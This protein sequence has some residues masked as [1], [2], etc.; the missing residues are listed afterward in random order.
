MSRSLYLVLPDWEGEIDNV[1][2]SVVEDLLHGPRYMQVG[3]ELWTL[4]GREER[5][6][7]IEDLLETAHNR[8]S[9]SLDTREVQNLERLLD[10]LDDALRPLLDDKWQIRPENMEDVRKR[11]TLL[12]LEDE[13]GQIGSNGVT[14][15]LSEVHELRAFLRLAI[16]RG[17]NL[18]MG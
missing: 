8:S 13:G 15:G 17:L 5:A 3:Q 6:K 4:A 1:H 7:E 18:R 10:G 11:T 9:L 14:E 2:E 16:E 12:H